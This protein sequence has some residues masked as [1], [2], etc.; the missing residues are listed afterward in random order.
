[1]LLALFRYWMHDW[2]HFSL[3]RLSCYDFLRSCLPQWLVHVLRL[4]L[5]GD[6]SPSRTSQS[7]GT[8]PSRPCREVISQNTAEIRWGESVD[9]SLLLPDFYLRSLPL[10][11]VTRTHPQA[12]RVPQLPCYVKR[13]PWVGDRFF[14]QVSRCICFGSILSVV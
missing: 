9:F 13:S 1:M 7:I 6:N 3:N 5:L 2:S 14:L 10:S 8:S 11:F 4:S 12:P